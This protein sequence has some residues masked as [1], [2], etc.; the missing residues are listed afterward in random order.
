MLQGIQYLRGAAAFMIVYYHS[1]GPLER[2]TGHRIPLSF[3]EFG[4]D[5]FFV[6]SGMVMWLSTHDGHIGPGEFLKNRFRRVAPL[7]WAIT[8]LIS[9]VALLAPSLLR[10]TAFD[11]A[12]FVASLAF[13]P[14]PNPTYPGFWPLLI[15]G[16]TL[17]YEMFFYVIFA[18]M[19]MLSPIFRAAG[20]ISALVFLSLMGNYMEPAGFLR[21]YTKPII[22]NFAF[23]IISGII[24]TSKLTIDKISSIV[25]AVF[26]F[27]LLCFLHDIGGAPRLIAAGL[28]SMM[29]VSGLAMLEKSCSM[30]R[31]APL[32]HLGASSYSLYLIHPVILSALAI[33]LG[34]FTIV[35]DSHWTFSLL[36]LLSGSLLAGSILHFVAEKPL[37]RLARG[38]L[39]QKPQQAV[40][41]RVDG[42]GS[43]SVGG[44]SAAG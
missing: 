10:S 9:I 33:G 3:S 40:S 30:I 14:W 20:V 43:R 25:I 8:I 11:P 1:A 41:A 38:L 42:N 18:A 31:I 16:W 34:K 5:L 23:G 26:G 13:I 12:H 21:Y 27:I 2:I 28:P 35:A 32:D 37:D 15:P 29:I 17:N 36:L 24:Y 7:Y 44:I 39:G 6:I 19:L 22:L 4:V